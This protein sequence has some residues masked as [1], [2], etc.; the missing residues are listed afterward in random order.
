LVVAAFA[1][2][3]IKGSFASRVGAHAKTS[4][5]V[6][7]DNSYSLGYETKDGPVFKTA[8]DKAKSILNQL[9]EGDEASLVLF[10][11][12][13]RLLTPQPTH[14]FKHL[15]ESMDEEAELS[16]DVTNVGKAL[17]TGYQLLKDSKN[18]NR[19][20]YLITDME[21]SGWSSLPLGFLPPES[22]KVKLYVV[23][24]SPR[25]R[26][27]LCIEKVEFG[28]QL[29]EPAKPFQ[30]SAQIDNYTSQPVT[31]SLVGLYLD[32]KRVSQTDTD[33][34][35]DG[36]S[37]VKF[38]AVVERA[39]IHTGFIELTDDDL[40]IDNRRY[41]GF[42]IP[43]TMRVLL[44]GE[45][46]RDTRYLSLALNP[47]NSSEAAKEVTSV[48]KDGLSGV[49]FNQYQVIIFSNL[50]QLPDI[51][52]ANLQRFLQRG[53]GAFFILGDK[54]DPEFYSRNIMKPFFDMNLTAPLAPARSVSGFFSL[55]NLD[56]D[57]PIFQVY[58]QVEKDQLPEIKF[59]S[60][61]PLPEGG[62]TNTL[63][64][65]NS[66]KPALVESRF[67]T[68][69][70]LLSAAPLEESE[71]DLVMHPFFVPFIHRSV[72]YLGSDLSRLDEDILVDTKV[73]REI[74]ADLAS[75]GIEL[76]DPSMKRIALQ[77]S[78][79]A[80][81]GDQLMVRI[82]DTSLPGIYTILS[83]PSTSEEGVV[84]RFAVNIDTQDSNPERM[85]RSDVEKKLEG[86]SVL[87]L[88]PQ[89]D[90]EKSILQSRYGKELWKTFLGMALGLLI[91]EMYLSRSRKKD[92]ATEEQT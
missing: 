89:D 11:S 13:P 70:V 7:L 53:G 44:V 86:L 66:G 54:I 33:I 55:E 34:D 57:H 32:G 42:R 35:K 1:R 58:R 37:T 6:L 68:G 24:V 78:F 45:T 41:F 12:T 84:D 51:Q 56:L 25:E 80:G 38:S 64:R 71:G 90:L 69:K 92:T 91:L 8:K 9:K 19:E 29:I 20:I 10:N 28:H 16:A 40:M 85:E 47:L 77:P 14:D 67:G 17:E 61:F 76:V 15:A 31:Q 74:P 22:K 3:A 81:G 88:S 27:N 63:A 23:D 4:V 75:Q 26:Q 82:E 49:D 62:K 21:K 73:T 60:I 50:S 18:L 39:G 79:A 5:V 83:H 46:E 30:L 43:E 48:S 87:Y 2:P 59:F 36:K 72:E 52:L 65:F